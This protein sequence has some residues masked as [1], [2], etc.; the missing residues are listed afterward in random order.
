[1]R[2]Q[3]EAEQRVLSS[4]SSGVRP[5]FADPVFRYNEFAHDGAGERTTDIGERRT[6]NAPLR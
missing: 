1:M 2:G 3:P 6:E 5:Q 4:A